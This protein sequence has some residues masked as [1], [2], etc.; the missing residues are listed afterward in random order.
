MLGIVIIAG[1]FSILDIVSGIIKLDFK[2][3]RI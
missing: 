1:S 2:K 3:F